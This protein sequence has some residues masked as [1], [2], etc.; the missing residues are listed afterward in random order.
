MSHKYKIKEKVYVLNGH[1]RF[2]S[3]EYREK[4]LKGYEKHLNRTRFNENYDVIG[5]IIGYVESS[6]LINENYKTYYLKKGYEY[7]F[8]VFDYE[9]NIAGLF[10]IK[11][12]DLKL[13]HGHEYQA[14]YHYYSTYLNDEIKKY[15]KISSLIRILPIDYY[16]YIKAN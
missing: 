14:G 10:V 12:E 3:R 9:E 11:E 4:Y 16:S 1:Y 6:T 8:A 2:H 5:M 13:Y 15:E 7:V